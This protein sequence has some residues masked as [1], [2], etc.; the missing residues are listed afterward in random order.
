MSHTAYPEYKQSG[1]QW[2]GQVPGH[3]E[4]DRCK[5][6]IQSVING[7]WGSEPDEE[8]DLVCVRV[9]DFDRTAFRVVDEPPTIRAVETSQRSNRLLQK[10]DLLI[11]KSR[12]S[13]SKIA[14]ER[15]SG[16]VWRVSQ[17]VPIG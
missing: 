6:S 8:N 5:W 7:I 14:L 16:A 1:V 17:Y 13:Y 12:G 3:W 9:A 4:V 15:R 2:L 10:G 11:P